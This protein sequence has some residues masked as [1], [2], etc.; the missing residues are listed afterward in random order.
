MKLNL[1]IATLVLGALVFT[2]LARAAEP[3]AGANPYRAIVKHNT[4]GLVPPPSTVV[5]NAATSPPDITLNGIMVV[6]GR[7]YALFKLPASKGGKNYLLAEG[8]SDGE[9][10]LL[11][12]DNRAGT[13]TI[14]NHGA[15]QTIVLCKPPALL[16]APPA[17]RPLSAYL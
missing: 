11:A 1:N 2:G 5:F 10:E 8:Q 6:F 16:S 12:V 15:V 9:I 14:N 4:F 17:E 13:I 7:K 3:D